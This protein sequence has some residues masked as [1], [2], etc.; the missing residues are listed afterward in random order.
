MRGLS[1]WVVASRSNGE[2]IHDILGIV[3]LFFHELKTV[4]PLV[5]GVDLADKVPRSVTVLSLVDNR[6]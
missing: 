3:E 5:L 1:E 2:S 6:V 4:E